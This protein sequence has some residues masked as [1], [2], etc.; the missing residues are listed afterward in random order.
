M[1]HTIFL[2][3]ATEAESRSQEIKQDP[4]RVASGAETAARFAQRRQ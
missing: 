2:D 3:D 4:L 1:V